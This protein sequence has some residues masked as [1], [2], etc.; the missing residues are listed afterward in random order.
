MI[1]LDIDGTLLNSDHKIPPRTKELLLQ[2]QAEGYKVVL[3]SGRPTPGMLGLAGELELKKYGSYISAY[4]G[5]EIVRMGTDANEVIFNDGLTVEEQRLV[6]DVAKKHGV[7]VLSYNDTEIVTEDSDE[8][9][10][11]ESKLL[12][13]EIKRVTDFKDFIDFVSCKSL[14]TAPPEKIAEVFPEIKAQIGDKF[15]LATSAPFFIECTNF[16]VDKGS[17]LKQLSEILGVKL[18]EMV[19][20]GDGSNDLPMLE[21]VGL[22]VAMGNANETVKAA[23]KYTTF[24]NDEEGI[25][26]VIE[27]F[28]LN[29]EANV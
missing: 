21:I 5:A 6:F 18:E 23:C 24:S 2:A 17:G 13:M 8:Y 14:M 3:S 4:N 7:N 9:I 16:G 1:V 27:K 20:F 11:I 12:D 29:K 19:A 25:A 28:L 15:N 10:D 26:H 22:S